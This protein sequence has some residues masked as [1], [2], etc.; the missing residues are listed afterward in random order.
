MTP[1]MWF[2]LVLRYL[3]ATS[4]MAAVSYLV[5]AYDTQKGLNSGSLTVLAEVNHAVVETIMGLALLFFADRISAFFV[6]ALRAGT[7]TGDVTAP[8]PPV[9]AGE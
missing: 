9:E 7:K 5:T 8:K 2:A 3:G 1:R 6:P 4:I